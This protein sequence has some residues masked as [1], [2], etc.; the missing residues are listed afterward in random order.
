MLLRLFNAVVGVEGWS[1][2]GGRGCQWVGEWVDEWVC[3]N[4]WVNTAT[5]FSIS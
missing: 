1:R 3:V 5:H 2:R 4:G